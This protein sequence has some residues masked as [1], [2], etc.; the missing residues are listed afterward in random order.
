MKKSIVLLLTMVLT[1]SISVGFASNGL[2]TQEAKTELKI[3]PVMVVEFEK[4]YSYEYQFSFENR[5][6]FVDSIQKRFIYNNYSIPNFDCLYLI[7]KNY[8]IQE[9]KTFYKPVFKHYK[10][11]VIR[12][13]NS[14]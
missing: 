3:E 4:C 10:K 6:G 5:F 7:S 11:S 14:N 1:L 9:K 13:S 8:V 2:T 12:N